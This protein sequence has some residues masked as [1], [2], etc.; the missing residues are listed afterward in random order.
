[1]AAQP[2][3][4]EIR[5]FYD[6]TGSN[7]PKKEVIARYQVRLPIPSQVDLGWQLITEIGQQ[8]RHLTS[9]RRVVR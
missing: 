6:F 5:N 4:D 7:I 1:M 9:C 2:S 3:D 8:Q